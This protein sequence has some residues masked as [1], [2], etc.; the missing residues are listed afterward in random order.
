MDD[1][2]ELLEESGPSLTIPP[3]RD[4]ED[5]NNENEGDQ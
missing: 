2:K 4:N 3:T 1:E 5:N